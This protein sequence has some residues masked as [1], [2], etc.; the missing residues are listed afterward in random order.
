MSHYYWHRGRPQKDVNAYI[1]SCTVRDF[2]TAQTYPVRF[3]DSARSTLL[4]YIHLDAQP[5]RIAEFC[6]YPDFVDSVVAGWYQPSLG[7]IKSAHLIVFHCRGCERHVVIDGVH[8][9]VWIAA[10][11]LMDAQLQVTELSGT[12][13]PKETPDMNVVCACHAY[14][15]PLKNWSAKLSSW[16]RRYWILL[17]GRHLFIA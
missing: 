8:R 15:W 3:V 6:Q 1:Y 7:P 16:Q 4:D 11:G 13:W 14:L 17:R 10:N 12:D 2:L 5:I 9:I